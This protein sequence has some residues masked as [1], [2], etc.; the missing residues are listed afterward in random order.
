MKVKWENIVADVH[1]RFE[2]DHNATNYAEALE[3]P[4]FGFVPFW[5]VSEAE[6]NVQTQIEYV[7]PPAYY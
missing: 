7:Q 6:S 3:A 2:A 4:I 1:R 5:P